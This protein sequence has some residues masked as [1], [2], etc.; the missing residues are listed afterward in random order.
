[1]P[2]NA[3]ERTMVGCFP[4]AGRR[5]ALTLLPA[6]AGVGVYEEGST[7]AASTS[8][9][10]GS[11]PS[12]SAST[13]SPAFLDDLDPPLYLDDGEAEADAGG[14]ST[15]IASR[16]LFFESPGRSNSIVDSAEHPAVVVPRGNG[17]ASS[18]SSSSSGRPAAAKPAG[19]AAAMGSVRVCWDEPARPVQVFTATPR[20]EFLKSMAEMV[21][22]MGLDV[23]RRGGDRARL[24]E[25]LLCYI[26]LND[27]DALPDILGAFT[28][29]L[30]AL[31]AHSPATDGVQEAG[32]A[33]KREA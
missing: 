9:G 1:M 2:R 21:D 12:S 30:F 25:L 5:R 23:A 10:T 19:A 29:L 11:P 14:L 28:D 16:R 32:D 7:S 18:S 17:G 13:S 33:K 26:A 4:A 31:N 15:A 20:A 22:A 8:V 6:S 27:R 24:H 3:T